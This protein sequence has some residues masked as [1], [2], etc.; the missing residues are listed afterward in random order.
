MDVSSVE[1]LSA[2]SVRWIVQKRNDM[3]VWVDCPDLSSDCLDVARRNRGH[4][5]QSRIVDLDR[6]RIV[7]RV[8]FDF[9][10]P[11]N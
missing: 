8:T 9:L 4:V 6:H 11:V 10:E 3:G 7:R 5:C 2:C 1:K